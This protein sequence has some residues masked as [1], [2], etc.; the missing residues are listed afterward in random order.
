MV[1]VWAYERA[2]LSRLGSVNGVLLPETL[3]SEKAQWMLAG[4]CGRVTDQSRSPK[5]S[6]CLPFDY[7]K[8]HQVQL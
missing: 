6:P 3:V 4:K 8:S 7:K 5:N 2:M 1:G